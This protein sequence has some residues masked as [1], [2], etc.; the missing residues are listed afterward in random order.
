[1]T[2]MEILMAKYEKGQPIFN[3]LFAMDFMSLR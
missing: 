2:S 1:M 3:E